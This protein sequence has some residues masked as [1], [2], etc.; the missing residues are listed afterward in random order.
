MKFRCGSSNSVQQG[1]KRDSQ[2]RRCVVFERDMSFHY[3]QPLLDGIRDYFAEAGND[4]YN[5]ISSGRVD[6]VFHGYSTFDSI[7][8]L[9]CWFTNEKDV[10]S[11]QKIRSPYL[12]LSGGNC[13][14]NVGIDI[15]FER[16]GKYGAS[17]LIDELGYRS[18]AVIGCKGQSKSDE[19]VKEFV[20]AAGEAG[21]RAEVCRLEVPDVQESG[22]EDIEDEVRRVKYIRGQLETF[23]YRLGKPVGIFCADAVL[24]IHVESLTRSLGMDAGQQFNVVC[25]SNHELDREM[26]G[27]RIST[28]Q[29]DFRELGYRGTELMMSYLHSGNAYRLRLRPIGVSSA[30]KVA[31]GQIADSVARRA[32]L[33]IKENCSLTPEDIC[34]RLNVSTATL[35]RRFKGATNKTPFEAI[36]DERFARAQTA[37]RTTN[38]HFEAIAGLAGYSGVAQLRGSVLRHTCLSLKDFR[39][40][41]RGLLKV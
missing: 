14:S 13:C 15:G 17:Y 18:L 2:R 25:P 38:Y 36:D 11:L 34:Q 33:L 4:D 22:Y 19:R 12:N 37:L 23:L 24:G 8:A 26:N 3:V 35:Y 29:L 21:L 40:K 7:S 1:L 31:S 28:I 39:K 41:C 6:Y 5:L 16:I 20:E 10:R 32:I 27:K 30:T 9:L